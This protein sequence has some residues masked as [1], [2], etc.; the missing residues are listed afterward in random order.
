VLFFYFVSETYS[1][2]EWLP[3]ILELFLS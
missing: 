2:F 1:V 3:S